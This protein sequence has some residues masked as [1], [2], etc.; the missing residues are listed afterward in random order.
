MSLTLDEPVGHTC[1][2]IDEVIDGIKSTIDEIQKINQHLDSHPIASGLD[3]I[4]GLVDVM[5]K[6]RHANTE[7]REWGD[8]LNGSI[9]HLEEEIEQLKNQIDEAQ[10]HS[11]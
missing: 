11:C 9:L 5:E 3:H 7:L 8:R 2:L 10:Q 1:P 4:V 6:I